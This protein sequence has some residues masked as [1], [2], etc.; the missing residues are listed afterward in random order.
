M[1]VEHFNS[2]PVNRRFEIIVDAEKIAEREDEIATYELFKVDSFYVEV[3]KSIT[4][5][6]RKI[7][8]TFCS[9]QVPRVYS[10]QVFPKL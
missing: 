8:N 5:K 4:H 3:S 9:N 10:P 2:L 6:F 1:T 7:L